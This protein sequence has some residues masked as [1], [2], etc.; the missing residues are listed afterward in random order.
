MH[1]LPAD[2]SKRV[3]IAGLATAVGLQHLRCNVQG[4]ACS[5]GQDKAANGQQYSAVNRPSVSHEKQQ[6]QFCWKYDAHSMVLT[7]CHTKRQAS[8][9]VV[10]RDHRQ[11][12][13]CM[14]SHPPCITPL[15]WVLL[16]GS[17]A[18][19][20]KSATCIERVEGCPICSKGVDYKTMH[21]CAKM[22]ACCTML[23]LLSF[24]SG[25]KQ[26]EIVLKQP[27]QI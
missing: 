4:G 14:P 26:A 27:Q 17:L 18:A 16:T 2:N 22:S 8:G 1:Q 7:P 23:R 11:S 13:T 10:C 21:W 5:A 19:I 24:F 3:H 9:K 20:P 25:Q 12:V 15:R 6:E